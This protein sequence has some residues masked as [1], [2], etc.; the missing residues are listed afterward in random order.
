MPQVVRSGRRADST[1]Q[2]TDAPSL[3]QPCSLPR[4]H[5][6]GHDAIGSHRS[7]QPTTE[8]LSPHPHASPADQQQWRRTQTLSSPHQSLNTSSHK[9]AHRRS[10]LIIM[11]PF[12][13]GA[14]GHESRGRTCEP[15]A[16]AGRSHCETICQTAPD[17]RSVPHP[18]SSPRHPAPHHST[19]STTPLT[20]EQPALGQ[21]KQSPKASNLNH[22]PCLKPPPRCG[23][24]AT[25]PLAHQAA[26]GASVSV[27]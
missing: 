26:A 10:S 16:K 8:S 9:A 22:Q 13:T 14:A 11:L 2:H 1:Y 20:R 12:P 23:L 25:G 4:S 17:R 3:N 27:R 6:H 5:T 21:P 7:H 19:R 24:L 18:S 15:G